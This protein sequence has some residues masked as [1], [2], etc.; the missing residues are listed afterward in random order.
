M[1][2]EQQHEEDP[3]PIIPPREFL[4]DSLKHLAGSLRGAAIALDEARD[5]VGARPQVPGADQ[6]L[7]EV[8]Q[9]LRDVRAVAVGS[10]RALRRYRG[11]SPD[12]SEGIRMGV[13]QVDPQP[14]P[15]DSRHGIWQAAR[16]A[17]A[18]LFRRQQPGDSR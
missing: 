1:S 6:V 10:T 14:D 18:R 13:P 12:S 8:E 4:A 17:W 5:V 9:L 16:D 11:V 3:T 7:E 2:D 15:S